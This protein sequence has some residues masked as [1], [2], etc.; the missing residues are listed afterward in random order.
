[1][2][3]FFFNLDNILVVS[4]SAIGYTIGT[5]LSDIGFSLVSL[6]IFIVVI[7]LLNPVSLKITDYIIGKGGNN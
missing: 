5:S 1:M 6:V 3:K 4:S 2:F 7:F